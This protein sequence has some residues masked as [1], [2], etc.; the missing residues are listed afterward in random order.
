MTQKDTTV[1]TAAVAW[2]DKNGL[3]F[4]SRG[5]GIDVSAESGTMGREVALYTHPAPIEPVAVKATAL[6]EEELDTILSI[7][8]NEQSGR[9]TNY[10]LKELVRVYRA[11][12]VGGNG[13]E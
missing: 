13:H 9:V 11:A 2:T 1:S 4:L 8:R 10:E 12:L 6:D 5:Y 7:G 3:E